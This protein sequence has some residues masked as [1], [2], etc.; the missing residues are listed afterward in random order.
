MYI[1]TFSIQNR[2]QTGTRIACGEYSSVYFISGPAETPTTQLLEILKG[3]RRNAS[4]VHEH[5]KSF[6]V[7]YTTVGQLENMVKNRKLTSFQIKQLLNPVE[8][9]WMKHRVSHATLSLQILPWYG[10]FAM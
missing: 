4:V 1:L 6:T 2:D 10:L 5:P 9:V 7:H 8:R 3:K